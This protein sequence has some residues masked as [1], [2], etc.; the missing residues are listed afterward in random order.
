MTQNLI[1][2]GKLSDTFEVPDSYATTFWVIAIY[3]EEY[4]G[5]NV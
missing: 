3:K 4:S 1:R 2:R 5:G